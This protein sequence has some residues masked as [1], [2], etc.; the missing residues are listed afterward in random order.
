[1]GKMGYKVKPSDE[2]EIQ[3]GMRDTFGSI[4]TDCWGL[5]VDAGTYD[6]R[7]N[8]IEGGLYDK[9]IFYDSRLKNV[10][11]GRLGVIEL[12][13]PV[14][15]PRLPNCIKEKDWIHMTVMPVL[16]P[17]FRDLSK[18]QEAAEL[19]LELAKLNFQIPTL[20]EENPARKD[21][22]QNQLQ[23]SVNAVYDYVYNKSCQNDLTL[24]QLVIDAMRP[25]WCEESVEDLIDILAKLKDNIARTGYENVRNDLA[26]WILAVC[27]IAITI[28]GDCEQIQD[29]LEY[30]LDVK[31]VFEKDKE[32]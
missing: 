13:L 9:E 24:R 29:Y 16:P 20:L 15:Y 31:S 17:K 6:E 19:W 21:E 28:D 27:F 5:V 25:V 14:L 32:N 4:E 2:L 11:F 18:D 26:N 1:M 10:S 30:A 3:I 22:L 7:G 12:A 23:Q 8:A